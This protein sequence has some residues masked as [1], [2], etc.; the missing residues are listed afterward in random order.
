MEEYLAW[1]EYLMSWL[2]KRIC[3]NGMYNPFFAKNLL[4]VELPKIRHAKLKEKIN[5]FLANLQP[6]D[7]RCYYLL[8]TALAKASIFAVDTFWGMPPP[9]D[10][11]MRE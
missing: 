3:S 9:H 4:I 5:L 10:Q 2:A 8:F 11:I 1:L 7:I 6:I